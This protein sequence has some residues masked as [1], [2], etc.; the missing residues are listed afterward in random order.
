MNALA[1]IPCA[2]LEHFGLSGRTWLGGPVEPPQYELGLPGEWRCSRFPERAW[3]M[4]QKGAPL[5]LFRLMQRGYIVAN[6][7]LSIVPLKVSFEQLY[8]TQPS[9]RFAFPRFDSTTIYVSGKTE[10]K[11][12]KSS[13]LEKEFRLLLKRLQDETLAIS[14]LSKIYAHPAY[15]RIIAMGVEGIPFVL[16]ELRKNRGRW[17]Y[18]LKFMAGK[19]I[20]EGIDDFNE[21]KAAWLKWG[22]ANKHI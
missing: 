13:E 18:A 9:Y 19:D 14:S 22:H 1:V 3:Q 7:T 4:R 17:F 10:T 6:N 12:S 15:Q 2:K 8:A 11:T 20:S 5:A 16:K 21:A